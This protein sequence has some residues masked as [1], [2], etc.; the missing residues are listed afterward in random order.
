MT[1][2]IRP[3]T[4]SDLEH[5]RS[6]AGATV[7]PLLEWRETNLERIA[8]EARLGD[9]L[10]ELE[11]VR[12]RLHHAENRLSHIAELEATA[13]RLE[14]KLERM[15]STVSWRITAPL[16]ALRRALIDPWTHPKP[17]PTTA[18]H[19][20]S[21]AT[22]PSPEPQHARTDANLLSMIDY[23]RSWHLTSPEVAV[24][25]WVFALDGT[26]L[27]AVRARIGEEVFPAKFGIKRHDVYSTHR[28]AAGAEFSGFKADIRLSPGS[29]TLILEAEV[30]DGDWR[31]FQSQSIALG[32]SPI[33]RDP[34]DYENWLAT[35]ER[36]SE[37]DIL[38]I[39]S[40]CTRLERRPLISLL[41]PVY[42]PPERWLRRAIES[43]RAQYYEN[44]ELCIANDAS[45]EEH[46]HHVLDEL[47]VSD[48]RIRVV[49]REKNG[50]ISAAS[51]SALSIARGEFVACVDHDDEL[52]P[53]AL[54][55][56][57]VHL[58]SHSD[59][60]FVYSDEDK[61][62]EEGRRYEPYF[63]PDWNPDLLRGQNYVTHFS[64]YRAEVVRRV[65]GF[66]EGF[67]G[68]QDWDLALR[69]VEQL[70]DDQIAHIPKIL[71]HWRAHPGSTALLLAEKNYPVEAARRALTGHFE[72][73]G[74][75]ATLSLVPGDHWRVHY[76]LKVFPRVTIVIPTRNGLDLLRVCVGSIL[77]KTTY[78]DYGVLIVDNGSDDIATLE[79]FGEISKD[80]RVEVVRHEAPFNYSD[81]NNFGVS[82][83]RG[84]VVALMN[85]DIEV[86][87]PGWLEEMVSHALRPGVGAVGAMLYFPN[88]TIQHAGVI[89]G[90]GGVAGHPF[91]TL[92]RGAGDEK[93]RV[94][95]AQNYSAVTA[96]CMVVR[97]STFEA[98]GG[99]D[100][101]SLPV[102]FND[103]D[104]CLKV[105]CAG[106][107]NVWT[108]FA[109]FYHHE[110]ASRG[111]E[112]TPEK[113]ARFASEV[114]TMLH[115]WGLLLKEDPAYNPNLA[116]FG[117]DLALARPPRTRKP[118]LVPGV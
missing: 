96:A 89:L 109:E 27:R 36:L 30:A 32:S 105:R 57:A 78:P 68:S 99:F 63:K 65:G 11:G 51:N 40:H 114:Q 49:H 43:I 115:R 42:N 34:T 9:V 85:N 103:V 83:A 87:T 39:R 58:Q 81:L 90:L 108:P 116:L 98:A 102:A 23:P 55:E 70:R 50:H 15:R 60:G 5:L 18:L 71:Y 56:V 86:I 22:A 67:E 62:D 19:A 93:N 92:A 44:W 88:D 20:A 28:S 8:I 117:E 17:P 59:C 106:L 101:E 7:D 31:L 29:H 10:R 37:S 76:E 46:V 112:T 21:P 74:V 41:M 69:V 33:H 24:V 100:A 80:K 2:P 14:R 107:R 12:S 110:S 54:Y 64:V 13:L 52:P 61:I 48:P 25:G 77:S 16:R 3:A 82:R 79:W 75:N 111:N 45:T 73:T 1:E 38:A 97:R 95:L 118:W 4:K 26:P 104:F 53:N 66:R 94:R 47:Q 113:Q 91:K 6:P 84:A 72:R 35:Y